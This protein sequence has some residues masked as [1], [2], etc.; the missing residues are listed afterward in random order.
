MN[1]TPNDYGTQQNVLY[2]ACLAAWNLCSQNLQNFTDLKAFYTQAFVDAAV[3][4][5]QDAK[6]LPESRQT[7]GYRKEARINLAN[8]KKQVL[9]NWQLLKVYITK[10]FAEDLVK[11]KLE[12]AGASLYIKA[13]ADNWNAVGIL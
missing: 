7:I 10:A 12:V 5:I 11:T 2:S 1:K 6:Q 8:A 9:T 13:S 3:Q 4:G